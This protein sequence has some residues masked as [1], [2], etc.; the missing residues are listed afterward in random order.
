M[1]EYTREY[2][3]LWRAAEKI[4]R[5]SAK[6]GMTSLAVL[7]EE[8]GE[9]NDIPPEQVK[10][11]AQQQL[12]SLTYKQ[13]QAFEEGFTDAGVPLLNNP[14][15]I[16][17]LALEAAGPIPTSVRMIEDEINLLRFSLRK[18]RKQWF[19]NPR[20]QLRLMLLQ[21]ALKHAPA[22]QAARGEPTTR[23]PDPHV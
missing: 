17:R 18:N 7:L 8:R 11:A 21:K 23:T 20:M 12:R 19:G 13:Q 1:S 2:A 3:T 9:L 16:L 14:Q 5:D 4:Q 22:A 6:D 10:A 15:T